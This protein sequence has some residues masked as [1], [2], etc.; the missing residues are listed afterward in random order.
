ML[1]HYFPPEIGAPQS[2]LYELAVRLIQAG[3]RVTVV[4]G[5][6]NYPT[7]RVADGYGG[8]FFMEE[9]L[10][11]IH[12]LRTW[13]FA[14]PNRGFALRLLNHFSF[15]LS[16]LAALPRLGAVD[17]VFVES[18]PLFLGVAG[19][20]YHLLT[21]APYVFNVSDIWPQSAVEL[22]AVRNRAAIFAAEK[23]ESLC[24]RSARYV[25]VVT[26]G[27]LE[28][29][30]AR[31]VPRSRLFLLTNGVDTS[32]YR[33]LPPDP[34]VRATLGEADE[35]VVLYAGTHGL[36]QGLDVI[37]DAASLVEA[38][39][40]RFV[41]IGEGAEKQRLLDRARS[42]HLKNVRFISNQPRSRMP[43]IL[44][45]ADAAVIPLRP[46]ELFRGALPSKMFEAMAAEKPIVLAVWGEAAELVNA[47]GCGITVDPGDAAAIASAVS[48]LAGD[49][50]LARRMG[51]AGR[52]YVGAHYDRERL[53]ARFGDLLHAVAPGHPPPA[54]PAAAETAITE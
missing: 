31:G 27:I 50:R 9:D 15:M 14:T 47:A 30:A 16:S 37:L 32:F 48:R 54:P 40:V 39:E 17:V 19:I 53:A 8:R 24:Y 7:G 5:F 28:N 18:P 3:T 22:G 34:V 38:R 10:E 4:T 52:R 44:S 45:A 49:R 26:R 35:F 21:R 43:Q 42:E 20:L 12:V 29:L 1:T 33:P 25:T 51:A 36:A 11:G 13:V 6:P 41:L 2:R 23:L 46:L